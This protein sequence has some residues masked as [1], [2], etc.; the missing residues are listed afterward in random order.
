MKSPLDVYSDLSEQLHYNIPDLRLYVQK[1]CLSRYGYAAACHRHPDLEFIL[2]LDGTMDFYINGE[3]VHLSSGCGVFVNSGRLHYGFSNG[4][5]ECDFIAVVMH[6]VLLHQN[7]PAVQSY[8]E[9]RFT[10]KMNDFIVLEDHAAW[11]KDVLELM[12]KIQAEMAL[13]NRNMLGLLAYAVEMAAIISGHI[14]EDRDHSDSGVINQNTYQMVDYIHKHY[15]ETI[16]VDDIA[17][18]GG[19]CRSKCC[20]LF[21]QMTGQTPNGY[22][23]HYRIAQSCRLLNE[24]DMNISEMAD[25]CGFQS[26]SYFIAVF[27][28]TMGVSPQKY[29][30]NFS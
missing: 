12:K 10:S 21:R 20:R 7:I 5:E 16:S 30:K 26:A 23:T 3:V 29:R 19:M 22:L 27:K 9:R 18:S 25:A 24:T 6:P 1:D 11:Q 28:K 4:K 14:K 15:A 8:F 17:F 13:E 2:V